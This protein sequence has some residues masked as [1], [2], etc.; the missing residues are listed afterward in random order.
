MQ[1]VWYWLAMAALVAVVPLFV[2]ANTG[3]ASS[4]WYALKRYLLCL[5]ILALPAALFVPV[6]WFMVSP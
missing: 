5:G 2:W 6:Y 3:R 4:A 1:W